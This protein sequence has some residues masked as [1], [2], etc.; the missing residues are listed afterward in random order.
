MGVVWG[1]QAN[2][3]RVLGPVQDV[4]DSREGDHWVGVGLPDVHHQRIEAAEAEHCAVSTGEARGIWKMLVL[5]GIKG[6]AAVDLKKT[7]KQ[8]L[9]SVLQMETSPILIRCELFI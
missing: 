4:A 3:L 6:V 7:G 1:W 9:L 2:I 5:Q 8:L